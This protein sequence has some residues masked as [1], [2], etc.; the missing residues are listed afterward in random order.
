[1]SLSFGMLIESVAGSEIHPTRQADNLLLAL[2]TVSLVHI[3][4][5]KLLVTPS[6]RVVLLPMYSLVVL[7]VQSEYKYT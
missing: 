4:E 2:L 1:M 5:S 3:S 6:T 7:W